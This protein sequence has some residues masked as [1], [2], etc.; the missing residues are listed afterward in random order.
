MRSVYCKVNAV[1]G[2]AING[3]E[4]YLIVSFKNK[5]IL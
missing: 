2:Y 5:D 1:Q 4:A 3:L